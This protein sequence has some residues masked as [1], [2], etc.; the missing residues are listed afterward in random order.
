MLASELLR[1]DS[2]IVNMEMIHVING[3]IIMAE[4][5]RFLFYANFG[6]KAQIT[7][8]IQLRIILATLIAVYS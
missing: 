8:F 5:S 3:M 1:N 7:P 6:Y 2:H 4:T